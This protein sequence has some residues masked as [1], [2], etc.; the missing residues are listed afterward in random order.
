VPTKYIYER[1]LVYTP[2]PATRPSEHV[3]GTLQRNSEQGGVL[4]FPKHRDAFKDLSNISYRM[5][6]AALRVI[7]HRGVEWEDAST[8]LGPHFHLGE[9]TK[10][11][12]Y[13]AST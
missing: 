9:V 4:F 11:A 6:L 7:N 2:D 10:Q 3:V 1:P 12:H 13:V 8:L 5:V